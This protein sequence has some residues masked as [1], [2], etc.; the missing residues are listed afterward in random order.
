MPSALFGSTGKAERSSFGAA[1]RESLEVPEGLD[2]LSAL[3]DREDIAV[4]KLCHWILRTQILEVGSGAGQ[5]GEGRVGIEV[6]GIGHDPLPEIPK[7]C[8]F[9][10]EEP[11]SGWT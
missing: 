7:Q 8:C 11:Y 2:H 10:N 5:Q 1:N 4:R 3:G 6:V 9:G